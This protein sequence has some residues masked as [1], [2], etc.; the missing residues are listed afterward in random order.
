MATK[1]DE[2]TSY[3]E[4]SPNTPERVRGL[5]RLTLGDLP[6]RPPRAPEPTLRPPPELDSQPPPTKREAPLHRPHRPGETT[7]VGGFTP[8]RGAA[9]EP[10]PSLVPPVA[11]RK[12]LPPP[13]TPSIT[14][15]P[16]SVGV[17]S[18]NVLVSDKGLRLRLT[19]AQI[20]SWLL[21]FGIFGGGGFVAGAYAGFRTMVAVVAGITETEREHARLLGK[22]GAAIESI[23]TRLDTDEGA[24][25]S[26]KDSNRAERATA[27]QRLE[28]FA[29]DLEE[30]KKSLPKIQGLPS[31]PKNP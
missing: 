20:R 30:V 17:T 25:K 9:P 27:L 24:M 3:H 1:K 8:A 2:G 13:P 22:Q 26:E 29:G 4:V 7:L 18:E 19:W 28:G 31:K 16:A 6:K 11:P 14:P 21:V 10:I 12:P 5:G 15:V 23:M